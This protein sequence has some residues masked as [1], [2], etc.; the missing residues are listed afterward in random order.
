MI[1]VACGEYITQTKL[2]I[3]SPEIIDKKLISRRNRRTLPPEPRPRFKLYHPY[4]PFTRNV[5]ISHRRIGD[6]SGKWGRIV[7]FF[8]YCTL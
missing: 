8:D 7:I 2:C 4:A 1:S 6:F 3:S 5:R